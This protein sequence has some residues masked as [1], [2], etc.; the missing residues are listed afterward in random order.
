MRLANATTAVR[1]AA[2]GSVGAVET[3][4]DFGLARQFEAQIRW[5]WTPPAQMARAPAARAGTA[6]F[7]AG[8]FVVVERTT[9]PGCRRVM[10]RAWAFRPTSAP[11]ATLRAVQQAAGLPPSPLLRTVPAWEDAP[12]HREHRGRVA[13]RIAVMRVALVGLGDAGR[14]HAR[15]LAALSRE[16]VASW[17]AVVGRDAARLAR[18]RAELAVPDAVASFASLDA[19]LDAR[20]C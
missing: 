18:A 15:A 19:L 2:D 13:H 6:V 11:E 4:V 17:T 5:T 20:V 10:G 7:V 8:D 3:P 14:H 16:A 12:R 9:C 1:C